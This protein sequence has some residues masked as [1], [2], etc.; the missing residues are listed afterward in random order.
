MI[1]NYL[2]FIIM[3]ICLIILPGPDTAI[4][5]KN[6]LVAGKIGGVKTVFGTC[7]ALLIHTLAAVIG[8]SALIVKSALLF[9]IFKY[10]GAVYL[11]YIGIKALLAVRN[12]SD[13][14]TNEV[15]I[16]N[17]N[18]HT[19]CFRQGFLTNL[20]NPKIAVFFLTFLPQFLNPNHNTFIQLLVMGLTYLILTVIWFAFYIF[21]IDK[22][23]AF[24]KKPKTQRYIQGLTGI[25]LI[26]FGIKLAFERN[27]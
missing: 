19:S 9:S 13:L 20:L 15:P 25:V 8:L 23:S 12:T 1:E 22:I 17:E 21:L 16:N 5:T 4:A 18:K 14:N 7:V 3:S 11:V 6:T 24:M 10:V 2:L 26:G 27:N